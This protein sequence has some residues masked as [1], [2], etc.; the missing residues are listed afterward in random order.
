MNIIIYDDKEMRYCTGTIVSEEYNPQYVDIDITEATDVYKKTK[1]YL[2]GVDLIISLSNYNKDE[3]IK[4]DETMMKRIAKFNEEVEIK[5]L[6]EKISRKK[7]Q[8]K[9]LEEKIE[10][11]DKRWQKIQEFVADIYNI[12]INEEDEDNYNDWDW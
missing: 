4:L 8:L 12:D 5:K 6:E 2:T 1:K 7:K 10:D 3:T 9:E 11:R